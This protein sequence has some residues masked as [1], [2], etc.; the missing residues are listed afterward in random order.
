MLTSLTAQAAAPEIIH[1]EGYSEVLIAH[2]ENQTLITT[3]GAIAAD[4][5]PLSYSISGGDDQQRFLIDPV[6]GQLS[7]KAAPDF[8]Q[9][10]DSNQ[11]N[12]Y[13]VEVTVSNQQNESSTQNLSIA[14]TDDKLIQLE[15]KAWL[16]GAYD[17]QSG[18][19]RDDLMQAGLVPEKQPYRRKPFA[20]FGQETLSSAV[21]SA[22]GHDAAVDWMLLELRDPDEPGNILHT[23]AVIIQRDG[24]IVD[25]ETGSGM[26]SFQ[27][28]QGDYVVGLRHRNHLGVM[29]AQSLILNDTIALVDFTS[30]GLAVAGDHGQ[31]Q[32]DGQQMLWVGD[33]QHD[34]RIIAHGPNSD[35]SSVFEGVLINEGNPQRNANFRFSG[36]SR[37][38]LN[39]D[40]R[41]VFSGPGNDTNLLF[42]NT[43]QHPENS[44]FTANF[45]VDG[46]LADT[47]EQLTVASAREAARFLTQATFGPNELAISRLMELGTYEAWIEQQVQT[48]ATSHYQ[49]HLALMEAANIEFPSGSQ[50]QAIWRD[51]TLYAPD[52]LRQRMAHA[53][54]QIMVVSTRAN[55]FS[56]IRHALAHYH[57]QLATHA[58]GNFRDLLET[59]TLSPVMGRYLNM[60]RNQKADPA[61]NIHPDENYARE[62]MQLFTIGLHQLNMDGS[63]K[64]DE[65]GN[66][67]PTYTQNDIEGLAAVFT[68]WTFQGSTAFWGGGV[69]DYISPMM[70]WPSQHQTGDKH[71]LDGHIINAETMEE[72]LQQVLD[73]LFNHPN[74]PPFIAKQLIQRFVTSNPTPAYI[75]RISEVF[76]DNGAGVRG[77]LGAVI[78]AILL[79][80]EARFGHRTM[81]ERFGKLKEPLIR[82]MAFWRA[83]GGQR[84]SQ[85]E[86][87]FYPDS[88]FGQGAYESPTVFNFFRPDFQPSGEL[89]MQNLA[90]PEMQIATE[91]QLTRA[92]NYLR[93]S[94]ETLHST[95]DS[96][97]NDVV[98]DL[99]ADSVLILEDPASLLERYNLLLMAGRMPPAM[100]RI[101]L[102]YIDDRRNQ[103]DAKKLTARLLFLIMG[104]SQQAI[105]R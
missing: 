48:P 72:E 36:Y 65:N 99:E 59:V 82:Q 81:P 93:R 84:A 57:D 24:D 9:A 66:Q 28:E 56:Q 76:V 11:D 34:K 80:P 46:H 37:L 45:I 101:L 92:R 1:G 32:V 75:E 33:L 95:P 103:L 27:L 2:P 60:L 67:I 97:P 63:A 71:I 98:I 51:Q 73:I 7:F 90:A 10:Q 40:G 42:S 41:V 15:V 22:S 77:D 3:I 29:T 39:M 70:G 79:D 16:Q 87:K 31:A 102:R 104:S 35:S 52:Q 21:I 96:F 83:L 88:S 55:G 47:P 91:D 26:L 86:Y 23:R 74:V 12:Q 14:I 78:K 30:T 89:Q 20:Y 105:Q 100:K 64:L 58:F 4:A 43:L 53:L 18:L 85:P 54:G 44:A 94:A 5:E 13:E 49:V 19:M 61:R 68:G 69:K 38:D 17:L 25:A 8:E 6:S 50:F 62:I